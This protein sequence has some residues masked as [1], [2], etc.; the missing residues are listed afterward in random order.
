MVENIR[1]VQQWQKFI[2]TQCLGV[3]DEDAGRKH[4][5]MVAKRATTIATH[6]ATAEGKQRHDLSINDALQRKAADRKPHRNPNYAEGEVP[7]IAG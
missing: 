3:D 6:N 4:Q 2:E 7:S 5:V 1:N